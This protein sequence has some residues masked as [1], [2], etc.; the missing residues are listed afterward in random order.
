MS[1][2]Y[3]FT[4]KLGYGLAGMFYAKIG[5]ECSVVMCYTLILHFADWDEI[6]KEAQKRVERAE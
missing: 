5:L 3:L 4:F 2:I 6:S 1:L